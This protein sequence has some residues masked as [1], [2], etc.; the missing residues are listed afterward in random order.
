MMAR[1]VL[2]FLL[3]AFPPNRWAGGRSY[4][5]VLILFFCGVGEVCGQP[6]LD[7]VYDFEITDQ[8]LPESLWQLSKLCGVP[9]AFNNNDFTDREYS[10]AFRQK[11]LRHILNTLLYEPGFS[12]TYADG[13]LLIFKRPPRKITLSGYI[14]DDET[15]ERL[16]GAHLYEPVSRKGAFTNEYGFFSIRLSEK[17]PLLQVSYLG[18]NGAVCDIREVTQRPLVIAL[19]PSNTLRE[20]I[21]VGKDSLEEQVPS[22]VSNND[23]PTTQV[24]QSLPTLGGEIDLMRILHQLPGTQTGTDGFGGLYVRG[25]NADQN[26]VL[27]DGVP[28]YNPYHTL[29]IYSIFDYRMV[30]KVRYLRGQFPARFGGRI[31]SVVDVRT[32]EGNN[33]AFHG[34]GSIG[35]VATRLAAE[36]PLLKNKTAFFLS[37]RRSHLDPFLKSYS[38]KD[39]AD[40]NASGF[41]NYS[42]GEVVGKL[43][44]AFSPKDRLYLSFYDGGDKYQNEKKLNDRFGTLSRQLVE[45]QLL[46]WGNTLGVLRW[47]HQFGDKL[48]SNT[49]FTYSR[50]HFD[51]DETFED[52]IF[53]NQQETD[54][55]TF[56][57]VYRSRIDNASA[58]LDLDY[59]PDHRHY[60]RMGA[61]VARHRFTPGIINLEDTFGELPDS[62]LNPTDIKAWEVNGYAEDEWRIGSR[63]FVNAGVF[64]SYFSVRGHEYVLLDPRIFMSWQASKSMRFF[65]SYSKMNQYLHVLTRTGAGFPNDLWVPS[66]SRI[67]PQR[68]QVVDGGAEWQFR[69]GCTVTVSGYYKTMNHLLNY[70]ESGGVGLNDDL[71]SSTNWEDKVTA[72]KG[73]S[74]GVELLLNWSGPKTSSWLSY[75]FS[76]TRR[77]FEEINDGESFPFRF[78]LMHVVNLAFA[79]QL[80]K[81]WSVGANWNF[82]SGSHINLALQEWQYVRQNGQPD[83]FYY[84]LGKK[85]SYTLPT[86]HRLDLSGKYRHSTAWGQWS[87]DLGV[88][89]LY[90]RTNIYF[91]KP[92]YDPLT[93]T[94]GY[95]S[96]SLIPVLPYL[97]FNVE[98]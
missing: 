79:Y 94:R 12:F 80:D 11:P 97:S 84:Y 76:D 7:K 92:D 36:G 93:Q 95:K 26:L 65:L 1:V 34:Y 51:S 16:I 62:L 68:S 18:Y 29:G 45:T 90:N 42:F 55:Y 21:V 83:I 96:V 35:L 32:K 31:S 47:N 23:F 19:K 59:V 73:H 71:I 98:I 74:K 39:R 60:I 67:K 52:R 54:D 4:W 66:T 87:I 82:S 13:Q 53:E 50:F 48:F 64:W 14:E 61:T 43:N 85:N 49:T 3:A 70:A 41:Y 38:K 89:N 78:N 9:F 27:F 17:H 75:T 5:W 6:L 20:I 44:H 58:K 77:Q 25:G 37:G 69:P 81:R 46:N 72:G 56:R 63:I 28:I 40:E 57:S 15:G 2:R 8:T 30:R 91:I 24:I 33:K 86:Y 22:L 10:Y 88:Y